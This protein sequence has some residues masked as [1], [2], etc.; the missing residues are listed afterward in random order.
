MT[1]DE[2]RKGG[3]GQARQGPA[4][5]VSGTGVGVRD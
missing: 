3:M 1:G 2:F 4:G 5:S